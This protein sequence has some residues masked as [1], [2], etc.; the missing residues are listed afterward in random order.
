MAQHSVTTLLKNKAHFECDRTHPYHCSHRLRIHVC[1]ELSNPFSTQVLMRH[2]HLYNSVMALVPGHLFT[3]RTLG[4]VRR[5]SGST[6][7][8][9]AVLRHISGENP[10]LD[11]PMLFFLRI[12]TPSRQHALRHHSPRHLTHHHHW[13]DQANDIQSRE[14]SSPKF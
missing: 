14:D 4:P 5:S 13:R 11:S 2:L 6:S 1:V 9:L 12:N 10:L 3:E 7:G 8:K